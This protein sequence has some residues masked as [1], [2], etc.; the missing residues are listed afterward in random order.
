[1]LKNAI[2][3]SVIVISLFLPIT[4]R[5][6]RTKTREAALIE[7]LFD[8]SDYSNE[9]R[10]V[11]DEKTVTNVTL[12]LNQFRLLYLDQTS[13]TVKFMVEFVVTWRDEFL[14]WDAD[15]YNLTEINVKEDR[16]WRPDIVISSAVSSSS[17][18]DENS[19]YIN[20]DN[21]GTVTESIYG[22]YE[23]ICEM[24]VNDFP[25]DS[26]NCAV[27]IGPWNYRSNQV[28]I[29]AGKPSNWEYYIGNSEWDLL[30][31]TAVVRTE[32]DT[33]VA[34]FYEEADFTITIKRRPQFYIW[35]LLIPTFII[36]I[37]SLFGLFIPTNTSGEREQRVVLG[38]TTLLSHAVIL[39]IVADAMPKTNDLPLLGNF[40]LAE[41][42]VTAIGVLFS[43]L[44]LS[45]H[46]RALTRGW[47]VPQWV[48]WILH[49]P[50]VR[51]RKRLRRIPVETPG[52]PPAGVLGDLCSI[53]GRVDEWI[54][55]E[56]NNKLREAKT[57]RRCNVSIQI[58]WTSLFDRIDLLLL[59]IFQIGNIFVTIFTI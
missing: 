18:L 25:Y 37:V 43:V 38:L 47:S 16:V 11:Y 55:E 29:I 50:K 13:E 46:N 31:A 24:K 10:P 28:H 48:R 51:R 53:L 49:F 30:N 45:L 41:I 27:N 32:E 17:P 22:M 2:F 56:E 33:D 39:Q 36:T 34:F 42:F 5:G 21:D 1:M 54:L 4:C 6:K 40:I 14:S 20:L 9:V 26:Q 7:I 58:R 59:A 15:E 35:V 12:Q 23:N 3:I 8:D 52:A 44:I 57:I 19:R